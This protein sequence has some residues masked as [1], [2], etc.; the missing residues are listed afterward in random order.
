VPPYLVRAVADSGAHRQWLLWLSPLGWVETL[1]PLNGSRL[2]ALVPITLALAA[3][4]AVSL[5]LACRRDLGAATLRNRDRAEPHTRLLENPARLAVR[6]GRTTAAAWLVAV[7]LMALVYGDISKSA[8]SMLTGSDVVSKALERIGAHES[9]IKAMLGLMLLVVAVAIALV[10]AGQVG[11]TREEEASGRLDNLLV[12]ASGRTRWLAGRIAWGL[13]V[14]VV[15]GVAGGVLGWIGAGAGGGIGLPSALAA[16]INLVPPAIVVLGLG[17]LAHGAAPRAAPAV[18]YGVLGWAFLIEFI[19][20]V[21]KF[22]HWVL[23]TSVL[24]HLAPAPSASPNWTAAAAMTALGLACAAGGA[25][26]LSRRDLA[27]A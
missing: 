10:A 4:A 27:G 14:L 25:V 17:T 19:G 16:G 1:N 2:L 9:G 22:S 24:Y 7:G 6:L 21:V 18:A 26:L 13:A 8:A 3:C 11:A 20:S 12:R 15:C 5:V 23:D